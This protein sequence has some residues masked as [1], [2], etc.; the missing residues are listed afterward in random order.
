[1]GKATETCKWAPN[2]MA[3]C[4]WKS[5]ACLGFFKNGFPLKWI[6]Q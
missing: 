6:D 3:L 1:M 2:G 5:P 4:A